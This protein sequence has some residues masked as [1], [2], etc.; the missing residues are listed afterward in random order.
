MR[1]GS[2]T[3]AR[4]PQ[5]IRR[6]V[7]MN[8]AAAVFIRMRDDRETTAWGRVEFAGR[9]CSARRSLPLT[10]HC[11]VCAAR[12][13]RWRLRGAFWRASIANRCGMRA[14][15]HVNRVDAFLTS[16]EGGGTKCENSVVILVHE[17]PAPFAKRI[18]EHHKLQVARDIHGYTE[19][20]ESRRAVRLV[21]NR[22]ENCARLVSCPCHESV[23][24]R[25]K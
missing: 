5:A 2:L 14:H 19:M 23:S 4:A 18:T 21:A 1:A 22:C 24:R 13:G 17:P 3:S 6:K 7:E 12:V 16:F 20:V 15:H 11:A 10:L 8:N 25:S 9:G